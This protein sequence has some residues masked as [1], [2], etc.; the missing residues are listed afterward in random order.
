MRGSAWKKRHAGIPVVELERLDEMMLSGMREGKRSVPD[1]LPHS[2]PPAF[3][4]HRGREGETPY[5]VSPSRSASRRHSHRGAPRNRAGK[6][7]RGRMG[8]VGNDLR[9]YG[10]VLQQGILFF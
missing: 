3:S 4:F 2:S 7:G 5:E 1:L 6:D 8:D 10:A 9:C